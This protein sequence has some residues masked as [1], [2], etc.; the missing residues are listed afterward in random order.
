MQGQT[1]DTLGRPE[2]VVLRIYPTD[3]YLIVITQYTAVINV[4]LGYLG[5][6]VN[7]P[8][9]PL[10]TQSKHNHLHYVYV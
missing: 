5:P 2:E 7:A 8:E 3:I 1:K 6:G 9:D 4:A 10:D